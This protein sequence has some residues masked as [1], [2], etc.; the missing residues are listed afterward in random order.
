MVDDN[1]SATTQSD[2]AAGKTGEQTPAAKTGEQTPAAGTTTAAKTGEQTTTPATEQKD[3]KAGDG[4]Q[5]ETGSKDGTQ[6]AE[7]KAPE[8][9]ELTIPDADKAYVDARDL[10][11]FEDLARKAGLSNEDAQAY[12]EEQLETTRA[13]AASYLAETKADKTYGGDKLEETKRLAQS[14]VDKIR[15][16]GHARRDSF[17]RFMGRGGAGNNIEVLSFLADL[18]KA[19][20]EDS[21]GHTRTASGETKSAAD[22]LYDNPTSKVAS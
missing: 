11:M 2:G 15:P 8:K 6:T 9:Y 18:G 12:L 7:S 21:V 5:T 1:K 22:K 19:M 20:G 10:K 14:V 17:L 3:E 16:A 13:Q 4:K